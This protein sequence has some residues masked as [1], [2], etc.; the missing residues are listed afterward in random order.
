MSSSLTETDSGSCC[1]GD[2]DVLPESLLP[3]ASRIQ[4]FLPFTSYCLPILGGH[5]HN[6]TA[7]SR[8]CLSLLNDMTQKLVLYQEAAATNGRMSSSY[9]VEPKKLSSP[10]DLVL[11]ETGK[12]MF[13][14][15]VTAVNLW[16]FACVRYICLEEINP[17]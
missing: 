10:G 12:R 8:E 11:N 14:R 2:E 4:D 3:Q 6:W 17:T 9:P 16:L 7:I 1:R 13:P 15:K 5:P